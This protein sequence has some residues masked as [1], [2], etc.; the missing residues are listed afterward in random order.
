MVLCQQMKE[1]FV[2]CKKIQ[3][4]STK[5]NCNKKLCNCVKIFGSDH[6]KAKRAKKFHCKSKRIR[7]LAEPKHLTPKHSEVMIQSNKIDIEVKRSYEE[8]TPVRIKLL[9]Y[10][11]VRKLVA[12]R[13][14]HKNS[15]DNHWYGRFNGLIQRSLLTMY[16]RFANVQTPERVCG[17]KWTRDDWMKH[18]EWLKKRALPKVVKT[19]PTP[20]NKKVPFSEIAESVLMLSQPRNP[21][22]RFKNVYGYISSVD[23]KALLYEPSERI[24]KLALPKQ[25]KSEEK[26]DDEDEEEFQPFSVS[27]NALKYQP[28]DRI[29]ELAIPK[30]T[31]KPED[32]SEF[33]NFGVIKR[34]LNAQP[35]QRTVELSKPK[36]VVDDEDDEEKPFVNP[37]ALKAKATKRIIELAKPRNP[38]GGAN[39][40]KN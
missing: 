2:G 36:A 23:A 6:L 26:V 13:D 38:V 15:I 37:K 16:S 12:T 14:A 39:D 35:N 7:R 40:E 29:K 18:C 1:S 4:K 9:A 11:K 8:Q 5:E 27:L 25:R 22:E 31:E 24:V 33:T 19:P 10:P 20:K 30:A 28:T 21:R 32:L 3:Q 34:A 17:K